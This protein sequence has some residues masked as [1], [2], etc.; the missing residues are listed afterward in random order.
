M[1]NL[2]RNYLCTEIQ[3]QEYSQYISS[4]PPHTSIYVLVDFTLSS[5]P[6]PL[7]SPPFP[8]WLLESRLPYFPGKYYTNLFKGTYGSCILFFYFIHS[9]FSDPENFP[10]HKYGYVAPLFRKYSA[11][12][13]VTLRQAMVLTWHGRLMQTNPCLHHQSPPGPSGHW[14]WVGLTW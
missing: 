9:F 8:A 5:F 11:S 3:S 10:E 12:Y 1:Q 14:T 7:T 13:H 4:H 2:H 6:V